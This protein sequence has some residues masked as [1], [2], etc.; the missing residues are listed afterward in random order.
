MKVLSKIDSNVPFTWQGT[1]NQKKKIMKT[2]NMHRNI[3]QI[4][5][6]NKKP[7]IENGV[8]YNQKALLLIYL[9]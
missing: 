7:I 1:E 2:R 6:L 5:W 3:T 4:L 9:N 8:V